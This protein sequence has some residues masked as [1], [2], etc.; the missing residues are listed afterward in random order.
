MPSYGVAMTA[1]ALANAGFF[2]AAALKS[3]STPLTT[4]SAFASW[5]RALPMISVC[6]C[7]GTP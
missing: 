6:F 4:D 2:P 5:P 3:A 7:H 1:L